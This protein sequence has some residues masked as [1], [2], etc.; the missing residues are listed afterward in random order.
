MLNYAD[1]MCFQHGSPIIELIGLVK[2]TSRY[3][4]TG[5]CHSSNSLT[6]MKKTVCKMGETGHYLIVKP[7]TNMD[8]D[9][10]LLE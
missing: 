2:L 1:T 3:F 6:V 4:L 7:G 10:N 9:G 5:L 8:L